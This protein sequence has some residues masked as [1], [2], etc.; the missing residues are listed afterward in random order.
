MGWYDDRVLPR[1][2]DKAT[3]SKGFDDLREQVTKDLFGEVLEI[4]FGSGTNVKF[5]PDTVTKVY[6]VDPATIGREIAAP[7]IA[8][9]GIPVEFIG[10][11]GASL[12]LPDNSVDCALSSL[13]LCTIPDVDQ[14]LRE[15]HRV[16]KPGGKLYCFEHG[17]S[18]SSKKQKWQHRLNPIEKFVAGGCHLNRDIKRLIDDSP[19][20][21]I[22]YNHFDL[23]RTGG[24][25]HLSI[26][27]AIAQH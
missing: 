8:R 13:T 24:L 5:F 2:M 10:L 11:D 25:F 26:G 6:A 22:D 18:P 14:A 1:I 9:R 16:L 7:R 4:G 17:L 20:T 15:V 12:P 21:W 27:A 19:L 23:P 3:G